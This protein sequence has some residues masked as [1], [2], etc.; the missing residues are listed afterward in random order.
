MD[1]TVA[2]FWRM[3]SEQGI[4]TLVMLSDLGEGPKKCLRYWPDDEVSHDH[5]KV[6]YIQSESCPYYTRREFSVTNSK[7]DENFVVTQFQYN[8]W[9]TVEGEV[10]EVTRGLIELVDQTQSH[11]EAN[12]GTGPIT[13]HCSCGAERS[14]IFVALSILVQ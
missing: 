9:P 10:P 14:S 8:G 1:V 2:D 5:I 13:V 6:K 11:Q 3:M 7:T 12:G 4:T